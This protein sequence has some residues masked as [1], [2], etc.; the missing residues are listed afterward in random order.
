ME[1]GVLWKHL[2][3]VRLRASP[4]KDKTYT[5]EIPAEALPEVARGVNERLDQLH[6][7]D[8]AVTESDGYKELP[9]SA[10]VEM[11]QELD[12]HIRV[13]TRIVK[14]LREE[15]RLR[16]EANENGDLSPGSMKYNR[17]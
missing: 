5:L 1:S 11:E 16:Y 8:L 7:R 10:Q 9:E 13:L 15:C 4:L 2:I 14:E 3:P 12:K 6:A 17:R